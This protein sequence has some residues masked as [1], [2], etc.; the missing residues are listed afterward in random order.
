MQNAELWQTQ[1]LRTTYIGTAQVIPP[2]NGSEQAAH[3][4]NSYIKHQ[5]EATP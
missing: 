4:A 1:K 5:K 2:K 3:L